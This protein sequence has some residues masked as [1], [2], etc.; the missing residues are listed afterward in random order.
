[1]YLAT[2]MLL[3]FC[4]VTLLYA[5]PAIEH[6]CKASGVLFIIQF[7]FHAKTLRKNIKDAKNFFATLRF[8]VPPWRDEI[9]SMGSF[10]IYIMGVSG[11]GKTTIGKKLAAK[12]GLPFF[13]GDDFHPPPNKE[14]MKLGIPLTDEDRKGWLR[15]M[16]NAAMD[17]AKLTGAVIACSALKEEYRAI[18]SSGITVPLYWIFLQGSF[19]LIKKRI[20]ERKDHFMPASL[21]SSQFDALQ[22]PG[23]CIT[24]DISNS[25]DVI[26]EMIISQIDVKSLT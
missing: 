22:I 1:M 6:L 9:C 5:C 21:L 23:N 26:V 17:Q 18:L 19:E 2:T 15:Q 14:K 3:S 4:C 10:I 11:S 16:N 13:D 25:P 7:L 8:L 20:E 24:I 12:T